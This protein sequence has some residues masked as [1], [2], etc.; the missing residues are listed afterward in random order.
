[1]FVVPAL[2][3]N[4]HVRA[5]L[6]WY[7]KLKA[8]FLNTLSGLC[9]TAGSPGYDLVLSGVWPRWSSVHERELV[10]AHRRQISL[11]AQTGE[12]ANFQR[13]HEAGTIIF[14]EWH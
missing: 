11:M 12:S 2:A 4:S 10:K 1:M 6:R 9:G 8:P 13:S 5:L 7:H 14:I 3:G